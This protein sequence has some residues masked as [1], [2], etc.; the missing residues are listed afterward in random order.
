M[1]NLR[2]LL[3]ALP[4]DDSFLRKVPIPGVQG[5]CLLEVDLARGLA[6]GSP[7]SPIEAY[8]SRH[9]PTLASLV[10]G[11][12]QA[13]D[14]ARVLG[15]FVHCAG[16]APLARVAE[17]R[18]AVRAFSA[19][20]KPTLAWAE[21]FGE[22]AGGTGG[23]LLATACDEVW[24]QPSGELVLRGVVA[25]GIY[26][27]GALD[28][29]GVLPQTSQRKEYKS[30]FDTF[31]RED[32]SEAEREMLTALV[33]SVNA[34]AVEDIA[35]ARDLEPQAVRAYLDEGLLPAQQA[36]EQGLV[37]HLGYRDEALAAL[38]RRARDD[39][40]SAELRY[41]DRYRSSLPGLQTVS[42]RGKPV[43]AVVQAI[44][45]IHLGRSGSR[46]FEG[47]SVG[48]DT[49]GAVLRQAGRDKH[50]KAVVLR[51]DSPGGSYVASDAIR[52][53]VLN[54]REEG[55]PVVASMGVVAASGGYFI[56]M[57]CQAIV[58]NA[59]T[60]TG[61]IGVL[62][63]KQVVSDGLRK[64]GIQMEGVAQGEHD[65]MFS[66]RRPFTDEEWERLNSWLDQVYED[67]TRKAS[68]DRLML[69]EDLEPLARGRV[70]T[71]ADAA[72]RGL[73]DEVGGMEEAIARACAAAELDRSDVDVRILPKVGPLDMLMPAESSE[74]TSAAVPAG[75]ER[76]ITELGGA[77][78]LGVPGLAESSLLG[79]A[80]R[81]FA[82]HSQGV[83][84]MPD[85]RV[86]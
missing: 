2:E 45:P 8:R 51:V 10:D 79:A 28:K 75:P 32:M 66:S 33:A 27:R 37:D 54:L 30:G 56:A 70:W 58:A 77:L 57:P 83:L 9:T 20:G 31:T 55:T 23:Y 41:V 18:R 19:A 26:A 17:L 1:V 63:G 43:V 65:E 42:K 85:I 16:G 52:R 13:A 76:L 44:G 59:Q 5:R 29:L 72:Q 68:R 49:I 48:S 80:L 82:T 53:E 11:L 84:T 69:W 78:G 25:Q 6:E 73:V 4:L 39:K 61:S 35:T 21:S 67:F 62:A 36:L 12:R 64:I 50:V 86:D 15:L 22:L 3:D 47:R 74:A 38:R 81:A 24:L 7:A 34:A 71:G 14:D 46:P 40:E 60:L